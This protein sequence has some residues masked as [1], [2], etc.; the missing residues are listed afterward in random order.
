MKK[1]I[2]AF[3]CA[4]SLAGSGGLIANAEGSPTAGDVVDNIVSDTGKVEQAVKD[5]IPE[6]VRDKVDVQVDT[7]KGT[8]SITVKQNEVAGK[9]D[10]VKVEF[11]DVETMTDSKVADTL[12][13]ANVNEEKAANV[14]KET[15]GSDTSVVSVS[16]QPVSTSKVQEVMQKIAAKLAET[17]VDSAKSLAADMKIKEVKT[18][19]VVELVPNEDGAAGAVVLDLNA[20][21]QSG[22]V[23]ITGVNQ[24]VYALHYKENGAV[25]KRPCVVKDGVLVIDMGSGFSPVAIIVETV[26]VVEVGE[27]EPDDDDEDTGAANTAGGSQTPVS[28]KTAEAGTA[29]MVMVIA[30]MSIAGLTVLKRRAE[31]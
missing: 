15:L 10:D 17:V 12:N 1:K 19:A 30:M 24:N 11:V 5:E 14:V 3:V 16:V 13:S 4:L 9:G 2:L 27:D 18:A 22:N 31:Q 25:D 28:P 20:V 26:D 6:E 8:V 21:N 23:T 29:V 7:T